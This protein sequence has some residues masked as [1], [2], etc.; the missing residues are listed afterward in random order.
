MCGICGIVHSDPANT[1]SES[2]LQRM[3]DI[4]EHRGPD[5]AGS[6][7]GPGVGLG[8]RRLAILDLSPR[9]HM[10]MATADGRYQIIYNGEVYNYRE[11]RSTLEARGVTF[12]SNTDTEVILKLFVADGPAM[13]ERLNGM[14]AFAIWDSI[15]RTLFCAR[16]RLGVKPFYYIMDGGAFLFASEEKALFAAGAPRAFD[17]TT[18]EELLCFRYVAGERTPYVG[19]RRLLPGHYLTWRDG[20]VETRR[21]WNL[22]ERSRAVRDMS[23]DEATQWFRTTFDDAVKLR[24]ISD[25]PVGVLLSGGLDSGSVATAL[26]EQAGPGVH[27]FTMRFPEPQYDEGDVA[28]LTARKGGLEHHEL[29]VSP[30]EL[31]NGLRHA[32]WLND[33]PIVHAS[34]LHI[35]AIAKY[36][37]PRVTVLLSGEGGD[38]LLGGYVRYRP[39]LYPSLL[40]VGRYLLAPFDRM[41]SRGSRLSKLNRFLSLGET[42]RFVVYNSATILPS[43]LTPLGVQAQGQ[44]AYREQVL[45][46]AQQLYP[47]EPV[48]QAM[49]GDQHTFL[50]SLLDR[51]DRMTMG[52]SI[53]CRPPFLDY[54]LV[55]GTAGLPSSIVVGAVGGKR[56][57]RR[58]IGDRL[59]EEVLRYRKWGFGV[60]WTRYMQIE[61]EFRDLISTLPDVPPIAD[62]PFDRKALRTITAR[63]LD[64]DTRYEAHVLRLVTV[65]IWH[66]ACFTNV[67]RGSDRKPPENNWEPSLTGSA[68]EYA[69]QD[70]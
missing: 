38:E 63:F 62:G 57:L 65:A 34:D 40:D 19:V 23:A 6:Y 70:A 61:P 30:P 14:F 43:E 45:D 27:S 68:V 7:V 13:L 3:R 20:R 50:C 22:A 29:I 55:E 1:V 44:F 37:K 5:D 25:V 41:L 56:L 18:W 2:V 10:P 39:L 26:A 15:R 42:D 52:A 17:A 51:N 69:K 21:W 64:G 4:M 8:S 9:G 47:D 54:R 16:D 35:F 24:R 59:P 12:S 36:A 60:P 58:A 48:R 46:E 28:Q 32:S 67:D 33:E 53:E 66:Q 31:M 49:Y 11:L